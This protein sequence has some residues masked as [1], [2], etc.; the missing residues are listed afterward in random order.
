M[1]IQSA[2]ASIDIDIDLNSFKID[3][4]LV[5]I[6]KMQNE[7]N[8][9]FYR[10]YDLKSEP[11]SSEFDVKTYKCIIY[12]YKCGILMVNKKRNVP[13]R[14]SDDVKIFIYNPMTNRKN[15]KLLGTSI[16]G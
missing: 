9:P 7:I 10:V 11:V 12:N 6:N 1:T 15:Y 4:N 8:K 2:F 14:F 13:L 16:N 3:D 5:R